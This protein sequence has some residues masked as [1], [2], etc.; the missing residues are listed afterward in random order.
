MSTQIIFDNL[1]SK[2]NEAIFDHPGLEQ[3][4]AVR[5][6]AG[7]AY[8][9]LNDDVF[10]PNKQ[11]EQQFVEMLAEIGD[12]V[13]T[14]MIALWSNHKT[15]FPSFHFRN[16]LVLM[17]TDNLDAHIVMRDENRYRTIV[18]RDTLTPGDTQ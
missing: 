1:F 6:S 16:Q 2:A 5:T 10:S 12:T 15:D 7:N 9:L 4:L 14:H 18:L 13:V 3:V 11:A 17:H 8:V